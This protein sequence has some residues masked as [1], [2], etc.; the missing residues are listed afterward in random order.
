MQT[1]MMMTIRRIVNGC[2]RSRRILCSHR[3]I[4]MKIDLTRALWHINN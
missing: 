2:R 1:M 4:V 3:G